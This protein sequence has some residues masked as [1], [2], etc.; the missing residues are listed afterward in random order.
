MEDM[1]GVGLGQGLIP[2]LDPVKTVVNEYSGISIRTGD[3][4]TG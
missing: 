4:L 1:N 3:S 2:M